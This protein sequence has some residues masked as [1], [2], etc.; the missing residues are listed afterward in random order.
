[1]AAAP[2]DNDSD[3]RFARV[4]E[5]LAE[6][7][8]R[9]RSGEPIDPERVYA[10]YPDLA[11]DLRLVLPGAL[12]IERAAIHDTAE[13]APE[14]IGHYRIL[15]ELGRGGMGVVYE[16]RDEKLNRS[17][18]VKWLAPRIASPLLTVTL[19]QATSNSSRRMA[20]MRSASVSTSWKRLSPTKVI[21]R[22]AIC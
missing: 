3:A 6:V 12:R 5:V 2:F 8:S 13:L 17:V 15:R 16:G 1:M 9:V 11:G 14:F 18:A 10:E 22:V 7:S 20:A 19:T 4:D 21:S